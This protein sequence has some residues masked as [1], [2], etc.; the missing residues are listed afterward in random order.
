MIYRSFVMNKLRTKLVL[1]YRLSCSTPALCGY[2]C[3]KGGTP[4]L[5]CLLKCL[6][7]QGFSFPPFCTD[8][9]SLWLVIALHAANNAIYL[10]VFG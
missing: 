7:D 2:P 4:V 5:C 8:G 3:F 6:S 10:G 1:L 9:Q